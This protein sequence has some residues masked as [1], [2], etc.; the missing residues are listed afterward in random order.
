[1][2]VNIIFMMTCYPIVFLMYFLLRNANDRNNWCFGATLSKERKKHPD[3]EAIGVRYRKN[4]KKSMIAMGFVPLFTFLIPYMSISFTIWMVWI[5]AICFVPMVWYAKANKQVIELKQKNGWTETRHTF[6]DAAE[7]DKHWLYGMFYS[8]KKD[9]R[10]MVENRMGTG[11]AMNMATGTGKAMYIIAILSLL[12]IPISC[13]WMIML[14]FTPIQTTIVNDTIV[15]EHLSVEYEI[16]LEDI[17][18]YTVLND[19]PEMTKLKGNGMD[20]VLSGT[21]EIYREGTFETFLNPKNNLFIKIETS[22]E[23]YY[24]SGIDDVQTQEIIDYLK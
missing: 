2:L 8:N 19:L 15:C 22:D 11:T 17:E 21:Y 3:V 20:H 18:S 6:S 5:L 12:I 1:M 9:K 16:P 14:D 23:M 4:L 10:I 13:I 7:D 24:I